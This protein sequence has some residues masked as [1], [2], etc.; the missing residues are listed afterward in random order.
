MGWSNSVPIFHE[1]V[2]YIL[3]LEIPELTVPYIDDVPCKGPETD[4][5]DGNG[6]YQ[7]LRENPGIRRFVWEHFQNINRVVQRMKYAGGTFSGT[8]S[9]LCAREIMVVGHRCTPEGRLP[10][11]SR[12]SAI[13]NWGPCKDLSE[14]RAFLGTIGVLRIFIRNFAKCANALVHLTRKDVPFEFGEAQIAAMED[15]KKA[16]LESSALRAINYE[17]PAPVILAVDTSYIAVGYHLCQCDEEDP[18]RRFY[19]RFGSIT[20]NDREARFSQPKLEL[21]GLFRALQ[22]TK[23]Y[24]I[25]IRNLVV[26]VDARYIRGMLKNPD[27]APSAS[28][29]RWILAILTFHFNL[30]HVPG[31]SHGPDGLSRR[32]AQ[33]G[34]DSEEDPDEFEDWI[35]RIHGFLH[36]LL[37]RPSSAR[38]TTRDPVHLFA[39]ADA[40][41]D[42]HN[43]SGGEDVREGDEANSEREQRARARARVRFASEDDAGIQEPDGEVEMPYSEHARKAD[44]RLQQVAEWLRTLQRPEGV[45]EA[46]YATFIKY[47]QGFFRD[48]ER[49]W[50]KDSQGAH[51]LVVWREKRLD[52]L[53]AAHDELGHRGRYATL[54]H[55]AERF[56]WPTLGEDTTWYVQTCH[57]C[58]TRQ[59]RK[60]LIPPVVAKPGGLCVKWY[61]DTMKMPASGG[62]NIIVVARCSVS[63]WPEWRMLRVENDKTLGD[64]LFQDLLCRWGAIVELVTDNGS[65]FLSAVRGLQERFNLHHIKISPYNSKANGIAERSHFDTRQVLFKAAGGDQRKW[66]RHA[67]YAFWA[68]RVTVRKRMGCSPYF[69][70]TGCHP[71]LPMDIAESTYLSPPPEGLISTEDLL[72]CRALELQKRQDQLAKLNSR[73]YQARLE[74]A[75]KFERDHAHTIRDYDFEPGALVLMRHTQIE[76]SLNRKMRPRYTGP[77]V[78][79]SRNRGGAYV[80]CEL[81]G[82]V[83]H[84]AIAAF[85]LIPYLARK[86]IQLPANFADISSKR[87]A[88]LTESFDDG[89]DDPEP[90]VVQDSRQ[91]ESDSDSDSGES[92]EE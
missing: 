34:D 48:G 23:L 5:R 60:V 55:I 14:V 66:S 90:E 80:L 75:R 29:N 16:L 36:H 37:P 72:A 31:T 3:R 26:E 89:T 12:V 82:S 10:D 39:L 4:Y 51:K 81:D 59:H 62:F 9:I 1:D 7:T 52:I 44:K 76:K 92:A 33:P 15:L 45:K 57:I 19:N 87:L 84:R 65:A 83:L 20:L 50:K 85:R 46:N 27:L 71:V 49:V 73:V 77:L 22:A 41:E 43:L 24:L 64:F 54:Q 11:D 86:S 91:D 35:D 78:V 21:Y 18:R 40:T 28:I 32:P 2:T 38:R 68:E 30:V 47:A 70:V 88:E 74:V 25:G 42:G 61:I 56:W 13:K 69:A 6:V 8:K 53:R 17:S 58:Q 79:V 63:A 67:H